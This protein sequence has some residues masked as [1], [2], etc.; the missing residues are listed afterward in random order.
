MCSIWTLVGLFIER[1][2]ETMAGYNTMSAERKKLVDI[3]AAGRFLA[4]VL[5]GCSVITALG[6]PCFALGWDGIAKATLLIPIPILLAGAIWSS[7]RHDRK[8][9]K[10][11]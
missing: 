4:R 2:P 9:W 6:I 3:Q 11:P 7:F 5:F 8:Y 10:K 1:Y